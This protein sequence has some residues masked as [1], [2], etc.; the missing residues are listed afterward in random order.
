MA[1]RH[2]ARILL[3]GLLLTLATIISGALVTISASATACP[4]WPLCLDALS[5]EANPLVWISLG[6]RFIVALA[7]LAVI[8]SAWMVWRAP[9][10]KGAPRW[11]ALGAVALFLL[12]ALAGALLVWGMPAMVADV[13]HLT[14]A[15]LA[16]GAQTL[17]FLLAVVPAQPVT[18]RLA[19]R[20]AQTQRRLR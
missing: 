9:E 2:L 19:G 1:A 18:E 8:G 10:T 17:T 5:G 6:H 3:I 7:L 12:Q 13:W 14:G 11:T 20:A 16:F 15:L 4:S